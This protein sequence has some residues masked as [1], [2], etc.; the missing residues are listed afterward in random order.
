ME[1]KGRMYVLSVMKK[2]KGKEHTSV[3]PRLSNEDANIHGRA[4]VGLYLRAL[5]SASFSLFISTLI[6]SFSHVII[7]LTPPPDVNVYASFQ[8][9]LTAVN[10]AKM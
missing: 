2:K 1:G 5:T 9:L 3:F 7:L 4:T 8:D 10:L 6:F